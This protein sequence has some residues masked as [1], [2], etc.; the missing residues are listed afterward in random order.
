MNSSRCYSFNRIQ[1]E[2]IRSCL[3]LVNDYV[4]GDFGIGS[5]LRVQKDKKEIK[6]QEKV[7]H[8]GFEGQ[9]EGKEP[10]KSSSKGF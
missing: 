9:K 1:I 3:N 4:L 8:R 2:M 5:I 7:L 6:N 10:D